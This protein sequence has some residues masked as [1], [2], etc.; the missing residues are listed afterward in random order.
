MDRGAWQTTVY[1]VTKELDKTQ[2]L[3]ATHGCSIF[4]FERTI[5]TV[6]CSNCINLILPLTVHKCSS[7]FTFL[8]TLAMYIMVILTVVRWHL[9]VILICISPIISHVEHLYIYLLVISMYSLEKCIFMPFAHFFIVLFDF[10][11]LWFIRV[12]FTFWNLTS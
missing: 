4:S 9:I 6:L 12:P 11:L 5:H 3:N 2:W 10:F 1:R 7:F 8:P